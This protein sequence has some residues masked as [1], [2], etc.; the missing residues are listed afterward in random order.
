MKTHDIKQ[1]A[2]PITLNPAPSAGRQ[3]AR[4]RLSAHASSRRLRTWL[5]LQHARVLLMAR[6]VSCPGWEPRAA[7]FS[8][9]DACRDGPF[10]RKDWHLGAAPGRCANVV[11]CG[12]ETDLAT[13]PANPLTWP[14][15]I[16]IA[17]SCPRSAP[18]SA[19]TQLQLQRAAPGS[20][21]AGL[22]DGQGGVRRFPDVL[23]AGPVARLPVQGADQQEARTTERRGW[24]V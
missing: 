7:L 5:P 17:T 14:D 4:H 11:R 12:K 8:S 15:A 3:L 9:P 21:R 18:T 1:A 20:S 13:S 16:A 22:D 23:L 6:T 24:K 10:N 19:A 2:V